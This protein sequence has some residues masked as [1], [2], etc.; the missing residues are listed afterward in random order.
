MPETG[1]DAFE[2]LFP[3][4]QSV[5]VD[6]LRK[7]SNSLNKNNNKPA[8]VDM[9]AAESNFWPQPSIKRGPRESRTSV[10]EVDSCY[11]APE[12]YMGYKRESS[13]R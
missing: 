10:G 5:S 6:E 3:A 7:R 9:V 2:S 12:P 4:K 11:T 13:H 1:Q 8:M